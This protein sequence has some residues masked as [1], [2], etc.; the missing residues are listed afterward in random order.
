MPKDKTTVIKIDPKLEDT[1]VFDKSDDYSFNYMYTGRLL[2]IRKNEITLDEYED[3]K[4][5][6]SK[7]WESK[8]NAK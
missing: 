7:L 3:G 1:I 2:V 5:I 6:S 4:L 8:N